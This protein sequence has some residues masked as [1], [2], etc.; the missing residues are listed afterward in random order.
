MESF[1]GGSHILYTLILDKNISNIKSVRIKYKSRSILNK[2]TIYI[3]NITLLPNY[4]PS[5]DRIKETKK[6]CSSNISSKI[7]SEE[8]K[9]FSYQCH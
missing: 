1:Y 8:W 2:P 3:T 6:F 7:K 5:I 4:L 9:T